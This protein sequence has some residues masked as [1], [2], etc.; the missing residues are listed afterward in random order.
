MSA[1]TVVFDLDGTLVDSAP[2]LVAT[3]NTVFAREGLAPVPYDV[4]RNMVGGGARRM[5]ELGLMADGSAEAARDIDRMFEDFIT[6]YAAHIA[7][8][9]QPFPGLTGAL[10]QLAAR[11]A[12]FAVCTNKLEWLSRRLL[13]ALDLSARFVAICGQDTFSV[14]KPDPEIL[15]RTIKQ[16]GGRLDR[17]VMVGDSATDIDT[18]RAAAVPV[19]AVDF[20]YTEI[21]VAQLGPDRVIGHFDKLPGAVFELLTPHT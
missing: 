21:P 11:G 8:H 13:D 1:F 17:S 4:A 16:A 2:D 5:I 9:S 14:H 6:Y 7:D 10:D 15:R 3:L 20:G 18:A 12:Q 19:I